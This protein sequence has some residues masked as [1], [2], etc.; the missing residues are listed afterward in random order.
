MENK[1][2]GYTAQTP[3]TFK[4]DVWV[5]ADISRDWVG[6]INQTALMNCLLQ[7]VILTLL[8]LRPSVLTHCNLKHRKRKTI[9]L[10]Y[11]SSPRLFR[12]NPPSLLVSCSSTLSFSP[13]F[14]LC[15]ALRFATNSELLPWGYT[16]ALMT[17]TDSTR[18]G[19]WCN[20]SVAPTDLS[21]YTLLLSALFCVSLRAIKDRKLALRALVWLL[22]QQNSI[23]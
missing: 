4:E 20:L 6:I 21:Y 15:L 2:K 12:L 7:C 18:K 19:W 3:D 5:T 1:W 11:R 8:S 23:K 22:L 16:A 17:C 9:C 10:H 14:L 13:S